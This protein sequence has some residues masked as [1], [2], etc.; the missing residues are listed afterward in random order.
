MNTNP[1]Q[2]TLGLDWDGTADRNPEMFKLLIATLRHFGHKVYIVTMRYPSEFANVAQEMNPW[3]DGIVTTS[4]AAKE[5]TCKD[6]G[7]FID[8][9]I[10]DTPRAVGESAKEIWGLASEEGNV[11]GASTY[12][13][14]SVEL[15][16]LA[17]VRAGLIGAG[18][19]MP[20]SKLSTHTL[21]INANGHYQFGEPKVEED[22]QVAVNVRRPI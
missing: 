22:D 1:K 10:E 13:A 5:P 16:S 19:K 11:V 14:T 9:W 3:V 4:R 17:L 18:V 15:H 20:A 7:I 6:L 8:V 12:S 2:I 21:E